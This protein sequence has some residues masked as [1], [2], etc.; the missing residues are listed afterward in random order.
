[1]TSMTS[2]CVAAWRSVARRL[3]GSSEAEA[4]EALIFSLEVVSFDRDGCG[5]AAEEAC[6]VRSVI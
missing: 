3:D 1:M 5:V 2:V 6:V 4:I